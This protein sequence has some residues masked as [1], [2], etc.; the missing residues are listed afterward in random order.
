MKLIRLSIISLT[1]ILILSMRSNAQKI[2]NADIK[3]LD[4]K[5][6]YVKLSNERDT[7]KA[8]FADSLLNHKA[9]RVTWALQ[10]QEEKKEAKRQGK[11][12]GRK[13]GA[14]LVLVPEIIL[15]LYW[16]TR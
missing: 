16:A 7:L 2:S 6:A 13:Q 15:A 1:L 12:T 8:M 10:K 5:R 9:E 11:R 3:L 4:C 14:L